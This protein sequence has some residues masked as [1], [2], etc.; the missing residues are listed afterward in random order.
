VARKGAADGK[1]VNTNIVDI[2]MRLIL[3]AY[4]LTR[5]AMVLAPSTP[6]GS[7]AL[8]VDSRHAPKPYFGLTRKGAAADGRSVYPDISD[9]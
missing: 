8:A 9:I 2:Q 1:S 7:L 6:R 4:R 3:L 5:W